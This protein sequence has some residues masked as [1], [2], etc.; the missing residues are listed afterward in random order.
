MTRSRPTLIL[1]MSLL[2][3][4]PMTLALAEPEPERPPSTPSV[5]A[6]KTNPP[7]PPTPSQIDPG[8]LKQPDHIPPPSPEAVI[9]PPVVDPHM[10]IDPEQSTPRSLTPP[11][12]P[13]P[14]AV[15]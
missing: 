11:P 10:A 7:Q 9:P 5:P 4:I 13:L 14:P 8:I 1:A 12:T 15:R 6:P 2:G 3:F